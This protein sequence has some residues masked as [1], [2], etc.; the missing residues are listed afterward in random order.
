MHFKKGILGIW[1]KYNVIP[2]RYYTVPNY[3][4]QIQGS[5]HVL[6]PNRW[7]VI[8]IPLQLILFLVI[9]IPI[10][11][12]Q[13]YSNWLMRFCTNSD[14]TEYETW[15]P[16]ALFTYSITAYSIPCKTNSYYSVIIIIVYQ[17]YPKS[18]GN[19]N[20]DTIYAQ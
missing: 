1:L 11:M 12:Y 13:M 7:I 4:I 19:E 2:L 20:L 14:K 16:D 18:S 17:T 6:L 3:G 8:V 9:L 5:I 10:T 15:P